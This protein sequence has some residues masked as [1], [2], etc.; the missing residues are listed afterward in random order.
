MQFSVVSNKDSHQEYCWP[1]CQ[2]I[3]KSFSVVDPTLVGLVH[4]FPHRWQGGAECGYGFSLQVMQCVGGSA[5]GTL[6]T[7]SGM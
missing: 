4:L 2:V 1:K 6:V 3:A 7:G 5:V